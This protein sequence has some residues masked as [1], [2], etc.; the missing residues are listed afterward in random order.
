MP[1]SGTNA[2]IQLDS[3]LSDAQKI[4][5]NPAL[6]GFK[7]LYDQGWLRIMQ[8]VGYPSQNKSHF[9]STDLYLTGNDGNSS[10][11]GSD[12]GW[13][14][15]FMESFY[16]KD[17]TSLFP[18]AIELGSN[19]GS[20][21]F[22]GEHEHGMAINIT[23]QDVA[24]FYSVLNGLGGVPPTN[25][26]NTDYGKQL[27]FIK[28]TDALSNQYA[29]TISESFA[30]GKNDTTYPN[31]DIANQ[32]KTVAK[33]MSGD[34]ETKV[35]MV[36]IS[37][38]D[39]HNAQVQGDN[40][41]L[42]NHYQLLKNLSDAITAFFKDLNAQNLSDDVVGITFSEFG[43]KAAENGNLGTDHGEI[44]PMFL[45]GKPIKGGVTGVNPD[46]T[47]ATKENNYQLKT[48]QYDY[49]QTF[50][51]L[52]QDFLGTPNATIDD[53]FFNYSKNETFTSSKVADLIKESFI[54][55]SACINGTE[56]EEDPTQEKVFQVYPN[57]FSELLY[58]ST[59]DDRDILDYEIITMGGII[60]IN[61]SQKGS[62]GNFELYL[63]DLKRGIYF[64]K[65]K[66][67]GKKEVHK[68]LKI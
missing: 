20:L 3:K 33:L 55:S 18:L 62:F 10:L 26:P 50:G 67:K 16:S 21:G 43:R 6:T 51:S 47:E 37:G 11:N 1:S 17:L 56:E 42:G 52:L 64:I 59:D 44:A 25:I 57:P 28:T 49:R 68:I 4:G 46:L 12:T 54:L 53:A 22:H 15:R 24:G 63:S 65:I 30:K 7:E 14:G 40:D 61:S 19:K 35:Y 31:T 8:S 38:F 60:L 36:R 9:K 39:T 34:L 29:K 23:G 48:V 27:E 32:L 66:N 5:L 41:I 58:V 2:Y 45:F 13:I